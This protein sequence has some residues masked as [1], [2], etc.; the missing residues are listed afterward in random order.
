MEDERSGASDC[1]TNA[2][3]RGGKGSH[4]GQLNGQIRPHRSDADLSAYPKTAS[5]HAPGEWLPCVGPLS[6]SRAHRRHSQSSNNQIPPGLARLSIFAVSSA[7]RRA[8]RS[9]SPSPAVSG[10]LWRHR[11][12]RFS[13]APATRER[14][15]ICQQARE[16]GHASS[17]RR[18]WASRSRSEDAVLGVVQVLGTQSS[19]S[20]DMADDMWRTSPAC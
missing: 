16:I 10:K 15:K 14:S 11:T 12:R 13:D 7:R 9:C 18:C 5:P 20:R 8:P 2:R 3:R 1:K 4:A 17:G 6:P 19:T